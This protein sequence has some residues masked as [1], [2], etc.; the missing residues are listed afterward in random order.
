MK[1]QKG[2]ENAYVIK[3]SKKL[4]MGYTT[5]SCA[6]AAAKAAAGMLLTGDLVEEVALMTPRGI[7]LHLLIED[8]RMK[9][10]DNRKV[11]EVSCAV[12]KDGG[13]DPDATH[14]AFIYATVT[15]QERGIT[16]D[17]GKGIGRVTKPGLARLVGEAAINPVPYRMIEEETAK[18]CK[19]NAYQGGMKVII[20]VPEGEKLAAK[21]FNPRLGIT[22]GISVLGTSGIVVPMSEDALI[23]SIRLEMQT[24]TAQGAEYLLITPGNYGEAFASRMHKLNRSTEMK[25]SNYVGETIDMAVE[26]GIKGILFIAHIGKFIKVSGG[27]MNTHSRNADCRAELMAAAYL[28]AGGEADTARRI[29][30]TYTTEEALDLLVHSVHSEED[31]LEK[32]MEQ[33]CEK[34]EFYLKNRCRDRIQIGAILFSQT[35]GKLGETSEVQNLMEKINRGEI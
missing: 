2:L 4:R 35:K 25:C 19:E 34:V 1:H 32:T 21:T 28:R 27:I 29:L 24:L 8:I 14:G 12:Q 9:Y 23:A 15:R 5:G 13:D 11:K 31:M 18:V 3:D 22:G 20:S 7:L 10:D 16:I 17:G 30:S 26:L 33:V 6:A